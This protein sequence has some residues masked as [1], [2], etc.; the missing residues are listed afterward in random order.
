[1]L[2]FGRLLAVLVLF[3][4]AGV[5][6]AGSAAATPLALDQCTTTSGVILAVDFSH[7][8][9]GVYRACGSTPTS[10]YTL[11]N[12]GGWATDGTRQYPTAFVCRIGFAGF[13]G[14][15]RY[16][17]DFSCATTPPASAY[18][19]YWHAKPAENSW[20]YSQAGAQSASPEPGSVDA[21]VFGATNVQGTNGGPS[22]SPDSVRAHNVS[23][24][25]GGAASSRAPAPPSVTPPGNGSGTSTGGGSG[26]ST[27][28]G[29]T[30]SGDT[31]GS[32]GAGGSAGAGGGLAGATRSAIPS[33]APARSAASRAAS[34]SAAAK[35]KTSKAAV[36]QAASSSASTAPQIVDA[37]PAADIRHGSG[38]YRPGL[39]A[40]A[41]LIVLGGFTGFRFWRRKQVSQSS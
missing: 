7:F 27:V 12:Q 10:G 6:G 3:G 11:L 25:G 36:A 5:F 1:M 16:P 23:P 19:S 24:V 2:R 35:A 31:A 8:G 41:I 37:Q 26:G 30:G 33:N 20:S 15:T 39:L 13:N 32:G 14:G 18:W 9:G 29:G 21:W 34:K 28:G 38:S 4:S 17:T 40:G 22:F